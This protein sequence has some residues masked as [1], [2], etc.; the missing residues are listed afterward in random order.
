MRDTLRVGWK[1]IQMAMPSYPRD[2]HMQGRG[3]GHAG[4]MGWEGP[5]RE[6]A[7]WHPVSH[8]AK[9]ELRVQ[10]RV[11]TRLMVRVGVDEA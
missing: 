11:A 6:R 9:H 8:A 1:I 7:K 4:L 2:P 5:G 10:V 3:V